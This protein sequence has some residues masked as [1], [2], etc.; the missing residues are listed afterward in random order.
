MS[1]TVCGRDGVFKHV[2][3]QN[4]AARGRLDDA[5][6]DVRAESVQVGR[7]SQIVERNEA[8][9]AAL[10]NQAAVVNHLNKWRTRTDFELE[11]SKFEIN[12]IIDKNQKN[13]VIMAKIDPRPIFHCCCIYW[14]HEGRI[15]CLGRVSVHMGFHEFLSFSFW[16]LIRIITQNC[17]A[18]QSFSI[19]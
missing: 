14:I 8:G 4:D 15:F 2:V 6:C 19:E 18:T 3:F 5:K 13:V 12:P 17:P 16:I 1:S 11:N 10:Y 9:V 7:H